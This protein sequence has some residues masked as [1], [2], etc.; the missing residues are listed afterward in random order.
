M[1]I[2]VA[3]L[4][5]PLPP[6]AAAHAAEA[7]AARPLGKALPT[8]RPLLVLH[9]GVVIAYHRC[10]RLP[11]ADLLVVVLVGVEQAGGVH[12]ELSTFDRMGGCLGIGRVWGFSLAVGCGYWVGAQDLKAVYSKI[13]NTKKN[14]SFISII[15]IYT[16]GYT[17]KY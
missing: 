15:H 10:A 3:D 12:H 16:F 9:D 13:Q 6:R 1:Q 5:G 17:F 2:G 11:Q 14:G 7:P 8:G 4:G